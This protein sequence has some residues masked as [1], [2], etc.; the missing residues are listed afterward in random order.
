MRGTLLGAAA[1]SGVCTIALALLGR[2]DWV[3]GFAVG[4]LVSLGNFQL[5][6]QA[7]GGLM[8]AG[9]RGAG[10]LWKGS[11]FRLGIVG[12]ALAAALILFRISFPALAAGLV[13]TQ[14]TMIT[15]WLMRALRSIA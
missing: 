9:A 15:L 13:V 12:I 10:A 5:I 4:A 7:V 8:P 2:W 11:V 1:V 14:A 6:V 3:A